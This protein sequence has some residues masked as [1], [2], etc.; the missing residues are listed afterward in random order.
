MTVAELIELLKG[1]E[2]DWPIYMYEHAD[3]PFKDLEGWF[4]LD[5]TDIFV[6]KSMERIEIP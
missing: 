1:F 5:P 6:N 3:E 2:P 4:K